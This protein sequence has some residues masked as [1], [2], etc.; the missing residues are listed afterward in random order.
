MAL[1]PTTVGDAI[2]AQI[3]SMAPSAGSKVTDNQLKA[4]WE[5]I[6]TKIDADLANAQ[7]APGT[8]VVPS[9]PSA[10]PISGEGGG[11]S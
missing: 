10:G 2:A 8:F 9:G 7:V 6:V 11:I 5:M 3:K 4:I 1:S